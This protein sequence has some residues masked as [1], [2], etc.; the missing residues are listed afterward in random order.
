M[1]SSIFACAS[2]SK[3]SAVRRRILSCSLLARSCCCSISTLVKR[4]VEQM[5]D[6]LVQTPRKKPKIAAKNGRRSCS[7]LPKSPLRRASASGGFRSFSSESSCGLDKSIC[8]SKAGSSKPW[9]ELPGKA[10]GA[11][12]CGVRWRG[13]CPSD[14]GGCGLVVLRGVAEDDVPGTEIERKSIRGRP[15]KCNENRS[16]VCHFGTQ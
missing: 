6:T 7:C 11:L 16:K 14:A 2:K 13:C 10:T 9:G 1:S 15:K 12:G 5:I 8:W 4:S 3:G